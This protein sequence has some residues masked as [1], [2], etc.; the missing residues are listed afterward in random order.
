MIKVTYQSPD[1][2]RAARVL[3]ELARLYLEKHLALHRPPG[4]HQFFSEQAERFRQELAAAETQLKEFGR[5]QQVCRR[6]IL[7]RRAP[8]RSWP[9]SRLPCSKAS[10]RSPRPTAGSTDLEAQAAETPSRQTTQ[11]RTSDNAELMSELKSQ[12]PRS[13]DQTRGNAAQ[14]HS[15]L[16]PCG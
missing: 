13:G 6:R 12:D 4:A 10:S 5:Q 7:K 3:D 15:D 11:I 2:I 9:S 1:P 16:S 8:F 14:V